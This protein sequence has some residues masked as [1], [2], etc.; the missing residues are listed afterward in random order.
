MS[1]KFKLL[2]KPQPKEIPLVFFMFEGDDITTYSLFKFLDKEEQNYLR[3]IKKDLAPKEKEAKVLVMPKTRRKVFLVGVCK[4]PEFS[5]QKAV[6][7]TR[8]ALGAAKKEKV[9]KFAFWVSSWTDAKKTQDFYETVAV[10]AEMANFEFIRYKTPP[11]EGFSFVE[12]MQAL[13]DKPARNATHSVAGG[14]DKNILEGFRRGSIIGEEVNKTRE[15][16]STP[17]G[18]MTP[19]ILAE[20]ARKA[21]LGTGIKVA[22]FDEKKIRAL[23]MGGVLGVSKGSDEPPRFIVMEYWGDKKS[24]RSRGVGIPTKA[25]GPIVLVGKGVTFDTGGLN[26]KSTDYITDMHMDMSGGAAVIHSIRAAAR[27]KLKKNIVGLIPAVEN[28]PSGSSYHPG[29]VLRTMSG[30]T[31]EVLN[32]DAEGRII[33]ADALS[34]AKKY[35]PELVVDVATLTGAAMSALGQRFTGLFTA[36]KKLEER[37]RSLGDATGDFVWPLPLTSDYEEEIK[38]TF[39]DWANLGKTRYGGATTAAV[40]LWQWAKDYPWVHLDIAPRMTTI[41]GEYLAKGAA[42][43][44]VRLLTRLL[45]EF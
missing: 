19:R 14:P 42:G 16:A 3:A 43:A 20:A 30:K 18:D 44:P 31:I 23:K 35:N 40:F 7:A 45:E 1:I 15:L 28:M 32:T 39:G 24:R 4:K 26:L 11:K 33:L 22:I 6:L 34:Y 5:Q 17:G 9:K 27:L 8:I 12:E 25:S 10:A 13:R 21:A 37:F 2:T 38:G 41:E 29:D 36:D